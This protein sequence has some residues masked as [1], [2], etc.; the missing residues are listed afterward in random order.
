MEYNECKICGA[1]NGRAGLLFGN[2]SKGSVYA[3]QN[4]HDTRS[5]GNIVI[6]AHLSRTEEELEKTFA[7]L[8]SI[9]WNQKKKLK[10]K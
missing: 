3:C 7:I 5:T 8:N 9:K 1:N 6:H 10:K 2:T 4:C